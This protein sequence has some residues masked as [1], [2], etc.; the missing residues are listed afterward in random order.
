MAYKIV[1]T[2]VDCRKYLPRMTDIDVV[3]R[4]ITR[5]SPN[6]A[7]HVKLPEIQAIKAAGKQVGIVCEVWGD[8]KHAGHGGV[9]A[10]DGKADG[11]YARAILPKLGAP[12]GAA[13]YFGVDTDV[14]AA[15][16]RANVLP[17][18]EAIRAAFADGEYRVGVYGPGS[19]CKAVKEAGHADLTWLANAKGWSGYRVWEPHC[20]V[21]Q[22]LETK[23]FGGLDVDPDEAKVDDWGQFTPFAED[24][25]LVEPQAFA[26][27]PVDAPTRLGQGEVVAERAG[28]IDGVK[29]LFKSKIAWLTGTLGG[30]S[31]ASTITSDPE[32][33][34]LITRLTH[35]PTFWVAIVAIVIAGT[36]VYY[37]WRDHG[38]GAV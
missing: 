8:I 25:S 11:A 22:H 20:D 18:F 34:S 31:A 13:V 10:V 9:S 32:T 24:A 16:M 33:M 2:P 3:I 35:K 28:M 21:L 12:S 6:G 15:Q 29:G 30:G 36:V 17:Y 4:Y 5:A 1:D 19:V 23:M 37:R 7:K 38:K 26:D 14:S 27:V